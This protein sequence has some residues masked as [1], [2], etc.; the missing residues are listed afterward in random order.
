MAGLIIVSFFW[1]RNKLGRNITHTTEAVYNPRWKNRNEC[2]AII[3]QTES[4]N[5][6]TVFAV[7]FFR[8]FDVLEE[9]LGINKLAIQCSSFMGKS[10]TCFVYAAGEYFGAYFLHSKHY[11]PDRAVNKID[12]LSTAMVESGLFQFYISIKIYEEKNEQLAEV[13]CFVVCA[14][15]L[16]VIQS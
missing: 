8:D 5:F 10:C 7:I 1:C 2:F 13:N 4:I 15:L 12:K 6:V 3:T 9:S 11:I 16:I 14:N